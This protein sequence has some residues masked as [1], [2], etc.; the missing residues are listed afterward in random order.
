LFGLL[1][2]F[3]DLLLVAALLVVPLGVYFANVKRPTER[4]RLD[5][6]IVKT[7]APIERGI[8]WAVGG[9]LDAWRRYVALG[10]IQERA[11]ELSRRVNRLELDRLEKERLRVENERLRRLLGFAEAED[12]LDVM[13]AR[14]IGVRL[15]PKGLQ[16]V[17]IDRGAEDGLARMMPVVVAQGVVGRV[18]IVASRTADV[19]LL[20]D[21]NSSIATRV[22][23]SR[24]RA[25]VRGTGDPDVC[26]LDYA[27]RSDDLVEGDLLVTSGTDGV[28]PRGLPVGR[29]KNL[30]KQG[31]GLYQKADVIPAV[32]LTKLE[33]V[34]VVT[35][36]AA[37][38]LEPE[39]SH[40]V[41]AQRSA[42]AGP[43]AAPEGATR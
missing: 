31:Q 2:R 4:S 9:T 18:H 14:V 17:T 24:A 41:S 38:G 26:R 21:R 6:F 33:E 23:R 43:R 5:R 42:Q 25:N 13:G 1:K 40:A 3:R 7:T 10:G 11:V 20:S 35:N 28:F 29:V 39:P 22:E 36:G 27:V 37:R 12:D 19:L 30:K 32:D 15:D 34:L 16:I 8:A